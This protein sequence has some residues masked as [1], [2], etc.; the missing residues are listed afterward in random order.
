V[1]DQPNLTRYLSAGGG[2]LLVAIALVLFLSPPAS[3]ASSSLVIDTRTP[4]LK[5][6]DDDVSTIELKFT[7]L[8]DGPIVLSAVALNQR[9]CR[10]TLSTNQLPPAEV[11]PVTVELSTKSKCK[12]GEDLK[13]DI[14]ARSAAGPLTGFVIDPEEKPAETPDWNQ[15][16]AFAGALVV[17]LIGALVLFCRCW[18]PRGDAKRRLAQPLTNLDATWKFNDNWAT[19]VSTAG[20]L[21]TGIF[22]TATAKAFLGEDAESAIGLAIVGAAIALALIAAAPVILVAFKKLGLK[23]EDGKETREDAFT[24]GG[25]LLAAAVVLASAYGQLWVVVA[26]GSELDLGYACWVLAVAA[27]IG[28]AI[29]SVYAWRSV[30]DLLERG[31]EKPKKSKEVEIR[32][33]EVIARA[34]RAE[35]AAEAGVD[36]KAIVQAEEDIAEEIA[37]EDPYLQ[38]ARSA[39]L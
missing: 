30:K 11:T 25:L 37:S 26:T 2:A 21:L 4:E 13:I 7:N 17:C 35:K 15:L 6:G 27:L 18:T 16:W 38:R 39:M 22:G 24:V 31:T 28:A 14:S 1:L 32:A 9:L 12:T 36:K 5:K 20:A 33:A 23:T 8:T 3:A 19:N 10:P 29:V 34:I